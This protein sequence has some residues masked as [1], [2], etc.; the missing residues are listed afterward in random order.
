[1]WFIKISNFSGQFYNYKANFLFATKTHLLAQLSVMKKIFLC[2]F[3]SC[4]IHLYKSNQI[5]NPEVNPSE[6]QRK[7]MDWWTYQY[8]EIMLSRDF[9]ALDSNSKKLLKRLF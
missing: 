8:N 5:R 7:F 4:D 6:I 9:V 1:M 2:P 3:V